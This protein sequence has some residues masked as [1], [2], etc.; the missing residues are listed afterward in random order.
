VE[1][2]EGPRLSSLVVAKYQIIPAQCEGIV[3][4]RLESPLG[5]ES[6]LVDPSPQARPPQGIYIAK[7]LVKDR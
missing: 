7:T 3:M 6:G 1:P 4:A 5:V 2:G